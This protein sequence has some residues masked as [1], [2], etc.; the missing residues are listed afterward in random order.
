MTADKIEVN[1]AL[2]QAKQTNVLL[3]SAVQLLQSLNEKFDL[4]PKEPAAVE[5]APADQVS[6]AAKSNESEEEAIAKKIEDFMLKTSDRLKI[7][8]L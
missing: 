8:G 1:P 3:A 6:M 2:D 5:S 7:L 4:M